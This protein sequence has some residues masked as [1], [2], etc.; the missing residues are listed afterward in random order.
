MNERSSDHDQVQTADARIGDDG[1]GDGGH[2]GRQ[3]QQRST[4]QQ[5]WELEIYQCWFFF[6]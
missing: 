5:R 2:E 4:R 1:G 6:F 3:R